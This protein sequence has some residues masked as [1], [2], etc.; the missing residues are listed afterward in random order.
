MSIQNIDEIAEKLFEPIGVVIDGKQY[1]TNELMP[2][3]MDTIMNTAR[4]PDENVSITTIG[5]QLAIFF[6]VNENTFAKTDVRKALKAINFI[7][8]EVAKQL[9]IDIEKVKNEQGVDAT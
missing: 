1:E 8:D 5:K 4:K 7:T 3:V 9:N 6:N 2:E